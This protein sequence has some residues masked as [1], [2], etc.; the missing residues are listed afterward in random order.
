MGLEPIPFPD[1]ISWAE[2]YETNKR[3]ER[4]TEISKGSSPP[5][6]L[7]ENNLFSGSLVVGLRKDANP[8]DNKMQQNKASHT[9]IP[10]V[11]VMW[12]P[13]PRRNAGCPFAL[14]LNVDGTIR[15]KQGRLISVRDGHQNHRGRDHSPDPTHLH[16]RTYGVQIAQ[17]QN[18]L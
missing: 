16:T 5:P 9:H 18:A 6:K 11:T 17:P 3:L 7:P 14:G 15:T 13:T 4:E 8:S 10:I 1:D 2:N 12:K